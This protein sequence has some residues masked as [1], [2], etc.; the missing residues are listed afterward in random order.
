MRLAWFQ[1]SPF[2]QTPHSIETLLKHPFRR[3]DRL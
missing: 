3:K 1:S 2:L